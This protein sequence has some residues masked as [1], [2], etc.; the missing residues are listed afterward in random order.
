MSTRFVLLGTAGGPRPNPHAYDIKIRIEDDGRPPLAPLIHVHEYSQPGLVM[1]DEHVKIT[2]ALVD[3]PPLAPAFAYR[4]DTAERAIVISG[5]TTP[6]D[7]L[8]AL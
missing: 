5:D 6:Q 7:S 3:H 2:A 4:F 8:I 1:Q